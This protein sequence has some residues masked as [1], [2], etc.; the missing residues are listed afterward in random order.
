[1][2]VV[3]KRGVTSIQNPGGS[4]GGLLQRTLAPFSRDLAEAKGEVMD[5]VLV[6]LIGFGLLGAAYV[7]GFGQGREIAQPG[8]YVVLDAEADRYLDT[9]EGRILTVYG[10]GSP[11]GGP[12]GGISAFDLERGASRWIEFSRP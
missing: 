10:P 4:G 5:K 8:R 2:V 3:P 12:K 11:L 1:M 6:G 9:A 7:V